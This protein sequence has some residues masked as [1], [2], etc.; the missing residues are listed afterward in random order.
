MRI[1]T[2]K[3]CIFKNFNAFYL[4]I[5][6]VCAPSLSNLC[7][8]RLDF[9]PKR[10]YLPKLCSEK[11]V[12]LLFILIRI[13]ALISCNEMKSFYFVLYRSKFWT[14][15]SVY[16]RLIT[17]ECILWENF[18]WNTKGFSRGFFMKKYHKCF[19]FEKFEIQLRICTCLQCI[20]VDM[21]LWF[22]LIY[23]HVKKIDV[24]NEIY[25]R[26]WICVYQKSD[27]F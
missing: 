16:F 22:L 27:F 1:K 24:L 5:E 6:W 3:S 19:A 8:G 2:S 14:Y 21:P 15:D 25:L 11:A 26:P 9:P 23:S 18:D 13:D 17:T 4:R 20:N 7:F 10:G 12:L